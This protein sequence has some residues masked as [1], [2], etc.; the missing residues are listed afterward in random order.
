MGIAHVSGS[1]Q[2]NSKQLHIRGGLKHG[3]TDAKKWN[4]PQ[5]IN[6]EGIPTCIFIT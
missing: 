3:P 4:A 2:T 1:Q 5:T 6:L